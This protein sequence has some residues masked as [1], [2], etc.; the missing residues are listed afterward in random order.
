VVRAFDRGKTM[1]LF[2]MLFGQNPESSNLLALLGID[3][4]RVPRFRDCYWNGESIIIHTRTGGG[5]REYYESEEVCRDNY[6]QYFDDEK[7]K[8]CGPWNSDLR[9]LPGYTHDSD[10]DFDSTYADFHFTP[11]KDAIDRLSQMPADMPPAEK[12]QL[13]FK[14]MGSTGGE[15]SNVGTK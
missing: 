9:K 4:E 2:N 11:P 10:D 8:P 12:W 15:A 14:V 1:S 6:P 7:E 13:L 3:Q 5:T